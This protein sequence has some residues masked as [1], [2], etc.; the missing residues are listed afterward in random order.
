M[1]LKRGSLI[2]DNQARVKNGAVE[3]RADEID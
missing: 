1:W 2:I 3:I